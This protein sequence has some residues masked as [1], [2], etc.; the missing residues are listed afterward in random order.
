MVTYVVMVLY[1]LR[2]L[3]RYSLLSAHLL[4]VLYLLLLLQ[5]R[6]GSPSSL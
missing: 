6:L 1:H 2:A 4:C 5:L 3:R